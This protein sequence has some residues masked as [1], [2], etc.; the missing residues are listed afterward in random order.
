M[1][2]NKFLLP[3]K[4]QIA[5]WIILPV[6]LIAMTLLLNLF[7]GKISDT[8]MRCCI[9]LDMILGGLSLMMIAFS[10]EKSEDE[11][12]EHLRGKS[13]AIAAGI[14]FTIAIIWFIFQ[15]TYNFYGTP[16]MADTGTMMVYN[17]LNLMS[18][19]FMMF[20]IYIITLKTNLAIY[21]WRCNHE[22]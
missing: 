14:T 13:L 1:K 3:Y 10:E 21:K 7:L 16:D 11:F 8:A 17:A 4:C 6:S 15:I 12:I 5:G 9:I 20:F 2:K 19:V 18:S 22:K